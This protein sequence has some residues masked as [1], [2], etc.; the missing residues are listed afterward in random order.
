MKKIIFFSFFFL[1]YFT[2]ILAEQNKPLSNTLGCNKEISES[3]FI[4]V[5]KTKIKKLEID[6]SNYKKWTVNN[7]KILT[8]RSR[9]IPNE[10]KINFKGDLKIT[11]EDN[12]ICFFKARIRHSGDAK[13][14]IA[15]KGNSV[16]QSL[17]VRLI[18]GNIRGITRF[19]L[20]KPDVRGNLNDVVLITQLLRDFGY[21]APRSIKVQARVNQTESVMLFQ[22]KASK[23]LLEFNNRR[24]GPILEGDQKFFFETVK[25]IPDNQLSNW[26]VGMPYLRNKTSKVMLSKLTNANLISRSKIHKQISLNAVNNLNLIYL[27]WSNRFQDEKNDYFFFDY[28]LD[29]TLLSFFDPNKIIKLDTFNL[30]LQTTNSQHALSAT[31]RKF[32]WN[33]IEN[34]FEPILY[35]AN[36]GIDLDFSTTTTALT[37]LPVSA[38]FEESFNNLSEKL[39]AINL[40]KLHVQVSNSGLNLSQTEIKNKIERIK[41]NLKR[42]KTNFD[43]TIKKEDIISHNNFKKIDN[44]LNKFNK[45]LSEIDTKVYLIKHSDEEMVKCKIYLEDCKFYKIL[46]K[47]LVSLL[48]GELKVNNAHYQYIGKN[49]DLNNLNTSKEY[50][51][52]N[53]LKS[54][55]FY[56]N[57]IEVEMNIEKNI[58]KINQTKI[59]SRA[60][61]INGDLEDISIIFNGINIPKSEPNATNLVPP[62]YPIDKKGLTGCLSF[63]NVYFKNINLYANNSSCEDTINFINTTGSINK[64]SIE[65]S[66]SDALDADFSELKINNLE[67]SSAINDCTDFSAGQYELINLKLKNCG[68][69]AISIGEKSN[70]KIKNI[71]IDKADIGIATKDSSVLTLHNASLKNLRTCVSAYKKKQEFNGGFIKIKNLDCKNFSNKFEID[72]LSKVILNSNKQSN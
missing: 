23:E 12:S 14:H 6:I 55:I 42:I 7:I 53:F 59:G 35:D 15:F 19:K 67:I 65:N 22:E 33:A 57:G 3:Y 64:V 36:P 70:V 16:I 26:S 21:L 66:F 11:Y 46:D 72:K 8:T 69:K 48:E 32:Y 30:F 38:Y 60:Y 17:D 20:F 68:D 13:D 44:I 18:N 41:E 27:Y 1:L 39:S 51:S 29:N 50:K 34:Y 25:D 61:I 28:D 56:E 37:R 2:H 4:N 40:N 5:D 63:I 10:L 31:N 9:F 52:K 71:D 24:E 62:N 43:Q 54:T 45:N 58:L 49:I 47:D